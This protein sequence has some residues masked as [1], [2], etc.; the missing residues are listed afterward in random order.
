MQTP[1]LDSD[2]VLW[3]ADPE[4]RPLIVML[5]GYGSDERDLFALRERMP[6]PYAI[7]SVRAPLAPPFPLDGYS[8]YPIEGLKSR[9]PELVTA[10]AVRLIEWLDDAAASAP[11][12]VLVGFSQGG[13]VALQAMRLA[14]ERFDAVVNLSGYAAGGDLPGDAALAE[15]RPPVFWGRGSADEVIPAAAIAHTTDWLPGHSE[16]VGRIY[17]GLAHAVSAAELDDLAVFL[18]GRLAPRA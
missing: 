14:P 16:L 6:D 10:A 1:P 3:S 7:A 4:A 12:V 8:W 5:H 9:D 13:A 11:A 15:R 2:A 17:P 18:R